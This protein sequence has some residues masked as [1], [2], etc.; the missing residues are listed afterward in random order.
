[1]LSFVRDIF[2]GVADLIYP[3][4]CCSCGKG[5]DSYLCAKCIE[6]I[7]FIDHQHCRTCGTPT[8][9]TT[10]PE[11]E[12]REYAFERAASVGV[13]EGALTKA[14]HTFK[15][16]NRIALAD[17]LAELMAMGYANAR[18]PERVDLVI[19]VPVHRSRLV[20]RGFNQAEEL[21]VRFCRL[22]RLPY[23]KDVLIK[24]KK[25]PH[26]V[27]LSQEMRYSNVKNVF[28]VRNSETVRGK[29]IL[30]IDDVFT[31]G[32]TLSESAQVLMDAGAAGVY[33]YT[34]ARSI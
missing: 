30:L 18:F 34:L 33:V 19:P 13:Y 28:A 31:T 2:N 24:K 1:M 3:P 4:F 9:K 23:R 17:R 27:E 26:Q 5:G 21:A 25:T 20:E 14:I 32:S 22:K 15:Y 7:R 8:E 11:C 6:E 16:D 10:C 29:R 12:G